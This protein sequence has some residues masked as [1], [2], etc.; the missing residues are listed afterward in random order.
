M[1]K[2]EV[3]WEQYEQMK[4]QYPNFELEGRVIFKGGG[5]DIVT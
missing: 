1:F 4:I 5:N 3:T 2:E